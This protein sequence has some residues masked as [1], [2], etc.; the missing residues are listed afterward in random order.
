VISEPVSR[1]AADGYSGFILEIGSSSKLEQREK[2]RQASEGTCQIRAGL[3]AL[4]RQPGA[5]I[6]F[7]RGSRRNNSRTH[8]TKEHAQESSHDRFAVILE[9]KP[10]HLIVCR[11]PG[12]MP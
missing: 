1:P 8:R 2:A 10:A 11:E 7:R 12:K 6:H 9:G 3:D 5:S 4:A